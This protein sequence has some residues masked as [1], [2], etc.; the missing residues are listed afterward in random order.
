M[1]TCKSETHSFNKWWKL[2]PSSQGSKALMGLLASL[3]CPRKILKYIYIYIDIV[4]GFI[5]VFHYP[6]TVHVSVKVKD[7]FTHKTKRRE[8]CWRIR[9]RQEGKGRP[10]S[11]WLLAQWDW[12]PYLISWPL[13]APLSHLLH[14]PFLSPSVKSIGRSCEMCGCGVSP[15]RL[16]DISVLIYCAAAKITLHLSP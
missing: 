13:A 6:E 7:C 2:L 12:E 16:A 9:Q 1:Q 15:T 3:V 8:S 5:V 10:S 11:G 4:R 14:A